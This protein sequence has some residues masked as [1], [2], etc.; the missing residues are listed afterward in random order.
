MRW[1]YT[2]DSRV[3]YTYLLFNRYRLTITEK[4][5]KLRKASEA[6]PINAEKIGNKVAEGICEKINYLPHSSWIPFPGVWLASVLKTIPYVYLLPRYV[7]SLDT[8]L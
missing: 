3:G 2:I 4:R 7:L 1:A 5:L 8:N 6:T